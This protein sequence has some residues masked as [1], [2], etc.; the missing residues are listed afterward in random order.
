MAALDLDDLSRGQFYLGLGLDP[1][2]HPENITE[3][4]KLPSPQAGNRARL[5]VARSSVL[6]HLLIRHTRKFALS[7]P[8]WLPVVQD[9]SPSSAARS[10]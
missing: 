8:S 6:S 5:G 2:L 1:S 4:S 3:M 10:A 9:S 7:Q